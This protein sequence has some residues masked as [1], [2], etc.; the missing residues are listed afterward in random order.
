MT[1]HRTDNP[2]IRVRKRPIEV[3]AWRWMGSH[4]LEG[5]Q[6]WLREYRAEMLDESGRRTY[7]SAKTELSFFTCDWLLVIPTLE[8]NMCAGPGDWIIRG[9]KGEVYPCKPDIFEAT[10]EPA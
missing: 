10:Y 8:G 9:V 7:H 3:D 5:A 4:D 6:A 1:D 2:S